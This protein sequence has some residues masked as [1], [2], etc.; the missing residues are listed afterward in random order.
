MVVIKKIGGVCDVRAGEAVAMGRW[1][2][3]FVRAWSVGVMSGLTCEERG[4][5]RERSG[6]A[7]L[8]DQMDKLAAFDRMEG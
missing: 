7:L 8:Q 2:R 4:S 5:G 3:R 6:P 1:Q